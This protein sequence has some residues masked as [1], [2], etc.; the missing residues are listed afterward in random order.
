MSETGIILNY[1][2]MITDGN[3]M[4][5]YLIIKQMEQQAKVFLLKILHCTGLK[6]HTITT[7][8]FKW[9]II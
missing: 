4:A 8:F 5:T 7:L 6:Y 3:K 9:H 2:T 1:M